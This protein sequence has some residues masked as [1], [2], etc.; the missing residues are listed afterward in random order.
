MSEQG[1]LGD[2][3]HHHDNQEDTDDLNRS[4]D[5]PSNFWADSSKIGSKKDSG[6]AAA[7]HLH[8]EPARKEDKDKDKDKDKEVAPVPVDAAAVWKA[9]RAGNLQVVLD[10]LAQG[11]SLLL[12][13]LL[14][15]R[16]GS[17]GAVARQDGVVTVV[18]PQ[19]A[20]F[21]GLVPGD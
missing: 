14:V 3:P 12:L 4:R 9:V 18:F 15:R 19:E 16:P 8:Q 11:K 10:G 2:D 21:I 6:D 7:D 5:Y 17:I 1:P 13:L 20:G